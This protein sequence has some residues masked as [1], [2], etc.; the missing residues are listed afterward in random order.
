MRVSLSFAGENNAPSQ[1]WQFVQLKVQ[2]GAPSAGASLNDGLASTLAGSVAFVRTTGIGA[3]SPL[4]AV[5]AKARKPPEADRRPPP[6][7]GIIQ[8]PIPGGAEYMVK[9]RPDAG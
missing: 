5:S 4:S 8:L 3:T 1:R 2:L 7:G 9:K 6:G